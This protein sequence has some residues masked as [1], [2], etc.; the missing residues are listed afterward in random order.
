MP[1]KVVY[2]DFR[3]GM[4]DSR[5]RRRTDLQ[6]YYNSASLI[7]NAVPT[8]AGGLKLRPG[9][10]RFSSV[11]GAERIIPF[12]K[13]VDESFIIALSDK[14][15]QMY[16]IG[17]DG[18]LKLLDERSIKT[19]YGKEDIPDIQ[20]SQ[21]Y[22]RI[23]LAHKKHKPF[24]LQ[25]KDGGISY[26]ELE[27]DKVAN[28]YRVDGKEERVDYEYSELLKTDGDYPSCVAFMSQRLWL[29]STAN[30]PYKLWASRPFEFNDFQTE[31][32]IQSVQEGTTTEQ[33]L[34]AIKG[35]STTTEDLPNGTSE[36]PSARKRKT[37]IKVS[38]DGYYT[39]TV[40]YYDAE[41][42]VLASNTDA[43]S[44]TT[45]VYGWESIAREDCAME[46]ETS[47][48]RDEKV[49]WIGYAGNGLYV[50]TA[51]SEWIIPIDASA[52]NASITKIGS[53]GSAEY[54]CVYGAN[55]IF[56][57]QSGRK[58][59]RA[60]NIVSDGV[61]FS[62]PSYQ[63]E[64]VLKAGIK[65]MHWQRV[66]EPRL[67][68]VL[69][70]G[71]IAVLSYDSDYGINA[72][73]IWKFPAHK[74]LSMS[75]MDTSE[76]QVPVVLAETDTKFKY[77]YRLDENALSDD[78]EPFKATIVTNNIEGDGTIPYTKKVSNIYVDSYRTEFRAKSNTGAS[79]TPRD[80]DK[81]LIK[82]DVYSSSTFDG[83]KMTIESVEGKPFEI[84]AIAV[85]LEVS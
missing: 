35:S 64:S 29:M 16:G 27:L 10:A 18:M 7:E 38:A 25:Y 77:L 43:T 9:L 12:T 37:E 20:F 24:T 15:L 72:W 81:D 26:G 85:E 66:P 82:M 80:F 62:E 63:C 84:L 13:S 22:E 11:I 33:Y 59:I 50:G 46:L 2:V 75:I 8:R 55:S 74:I 6:G 47:S 14:S 42:S 39:K 69:Y 1:S 53:Y 45:P 48:D 70:D 58:R 40:T 30:K 52:I 61:S 41:G 23:V 54:Q 78:G 51:S 4:I 67:Y 32:L 79:L 71:S 68:C 21:N 28:T 76:G 34:K 65:E 44:Y 31:D 19:E 83:M 60:I 73:C 56:Y 36:Y 3:G 17:T 5:M 57:L 49:Q